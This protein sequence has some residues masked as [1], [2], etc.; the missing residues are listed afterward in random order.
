MGKLNELP[1]TIVDNKVKDINEIKSI[2]RKVIREKDTEIMFVD[3]LQLLQG[4]ENA[5][6]NNNR[7]EKLSRTLKNIGD[8]NDCHVISLAQ[9]SRSVEQRND[10][11][12][13]MSDLRD[14]G[15]IEQDADNI[16]MVYR[17]EYY[18]PDSEKAGIM[19]LLQRK[20]RDGEVGVAEVAYRLKYQ[21]IRDLSN[22]KGSRKNDR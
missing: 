22:R 16:I 10:K 8:N 14:S 13:I 15:S 4:F 2:A 21:S 6:N 19:E 9:L 11:R 18:N 5:G 17:D 12:P 3:Y 1:L 20:T 7:V